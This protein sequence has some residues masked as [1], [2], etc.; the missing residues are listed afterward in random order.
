ML[1]MFHIAAY[2]VIGHAVRMSCDVEMFQYLLTQNKIENV[3]KQGYD[4]VII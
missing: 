2:L 4:K 1:A 3:D